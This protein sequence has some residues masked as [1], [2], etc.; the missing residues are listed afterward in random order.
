MDKPAAGVRDWRRGDAALRRFDFI[1]PEGAP[2][3][4]A[5]SA[6]RGFLPEL[7]ERRVQALFAE[8]NVKVNGSR[9]ARDTIVRPGDALRVYADAPGTPFPV[10]LDDD[11]YY[12]IDK[13][14]GVPSEGEGSAEAILASR[15]GG[16]VYACHRLDVM[17]GGLLLLARTEAAR[18]AA[19]QAFRDHAIQKTYRALVRGC[20]SPR[21]AVLTAYLAK[22][23]AA[24]HVRVYD[25]PVTGALPIETRYR[26]VEAGA[27]VSRLEID[28][29][30]GRT[31]QI[32]A[33]L[34]HIGH[35]VLGDDKY[36][37]RAFN[38]AHGARRQML[39]STRMTLWD[40]R[41]FAVEEGF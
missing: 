11:G 26:V 17:T 4:S 40:G 1:V 41:T 28:L 39:W 33:H 5:E 14:P 38:R 9:A 23:A 2:P 15:A 36:G 34:A 10:L 27:D 32:R 8:K 31:H 25:R 35:P 30:T 24:A 19:E 7:S 22:D 18:A 16:P 29:I 3:A 6:L 20:P 37:D 13:P 21:D 12:I